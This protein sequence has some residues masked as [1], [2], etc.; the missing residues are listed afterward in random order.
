[1]VVATERNLFLR[2]HIIR[3]SPT[4]YINLSA[5]MHT[6]SHRFSLLLSKLST[7]IHYLLRLSTSFPIMSGKADQTSNII[8]E[9][10][11]AGAESA[12]GEAASSTSSTMAD[13]AMVRKEI[14]P[15]YQ[16]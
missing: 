2:K 12:A 16:Y 14:P 10:P 11:A 9:I 6:N 13:Q 15:L 7:F 4:T 1:V 5:A 8:G 3:L